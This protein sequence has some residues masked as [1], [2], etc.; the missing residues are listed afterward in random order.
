M[1]KNLQ[2]ALTNLNNALTSLASAKTAIELAVG[3]E[4]ISDKDRD[5][6]F[7]IRQMIRSSTDNARMAQD[8]IDGLMTNILLHGEVTQ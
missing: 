2:I 6:L 7:A 1:K 3:E 8:H 4:Q 5:T